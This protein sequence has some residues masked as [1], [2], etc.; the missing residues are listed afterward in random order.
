MAAP[1]FETDEDEDEDE[2]DVEVELGDADVLDGPDDALATDAM[3]DVELLTL[4]T[5][6]ASCD[7][8][9]QMAGQPVCRHPAPKPPTKRKRAGINPALFQNTQQGQAYFRSVS[10]DCGCWFAWASMAVAAC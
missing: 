1:V 7:L 2:L 5:I 4:V 6:K 10:T 9:E 3:E 8:Y